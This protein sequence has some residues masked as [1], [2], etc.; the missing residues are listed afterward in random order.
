M[1][2]ASIVLYNTPKSEISALLA[3]IQPYADIIYLIDNSPNDRF[4][5]LEKQFENIR[6]IYSRNVGYGAAHNIALREAIDAESDFHIILNP[7]IQFSPDVIQCMSEYMLENL[8]VAYMLPKVLYPNGECQYLC[9]LLPTPLDLIFRRFFPKNRFSRKFNA[10]Y[11]L[12]FS[13][14]D[15]IINPPCLSGCFMF[16]RMALIKEYNLFFDE[17]FFMYC[18]DFDFIRRLHRIAKTIY[19]PN[20]SIIHDHAKES[21]KSKKM[22]F[23]HIKSAIKYFNK[24]GWFFDKERKTMNRALLKELGY[25]KKHHHEQNISTTKHTNED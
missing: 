21:Y 15:K 7:D 19:Y 17:R 18:E 10:R 9:K 14:Y 13:G 11:C 8:D 5:Q 12:K 25:T 2:T 24:W 6:Y 16:L 3:C 4:R 1:L 20:V 22:L 23:E